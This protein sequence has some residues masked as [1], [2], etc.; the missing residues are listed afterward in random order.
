MIGLCLIQVLNTK[1]CGKIIAVDV[2]ENRLAMA[3]EL[4]ASITLNPERDDIH[5]AV[6]GQSGGRGADLAFEAVGISTTVNTAIESVRKGGMVT[7]VGNISPH[8]ELP[9]QS[10][11]TRELRLQGSCGIAGEFPAVLDMMA[12]REI[13]TAAF[14]SAEAPLSEGADWF[15]RLYS[16]EA[17]LIKVVLIP[18]G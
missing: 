14:L 5:D 18:G 2:D 13:N 17:G 4:G 3:S 15:Q 1:G 9:L 12:R 6:L 7:L 10:V 8:V 11:V 16:K